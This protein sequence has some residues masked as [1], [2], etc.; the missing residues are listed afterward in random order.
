MCTQSKVRKEIR[1]LSNAELIQ[2][3]TI[4]KGLYKNNAFKSMVNKHAERYNQ[5]HNTPIF[6]PFHRIFINDFERQF[7]SNVN[8]GLPYIDWT[9]DSNN[10]KNS[11]I[12]SDKYFGKNDANG[13]IV[14]SEFKGIIKRNVQITNG[15]TNNIKNAIINSFPLYSNMSFM[16]EL[17]IHGLYHS[18]LNE[19]MDSV[20][21]PMDPLFFL[22]HSF[23]DKIWLEWSNIRLPAKTLFD[24]T[25]YKTNINANAYLPGYLVTSK[26]ALNVSNFCYKYQSKS[27]TQLPFNANLPELASTAFLTMHN[28]TTGD[29]YNLQDFNKNANSGGGSRL[30]Y[31][32]FDFVLVIIFMLYQL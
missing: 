14:D 5:I 29:I 6:L 28:F 16:V 19:V 11:V 20:Y 23:I 3:K 7:L 22:H 4:F 10:V 27:T 9:L 15:Y 18:K 1:D 12:F 30:S 2:F 13:N 21:S 17:G 25:I 24:N 8:F 32:L 26:F 31:F